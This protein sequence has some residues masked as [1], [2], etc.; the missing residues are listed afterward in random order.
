MV[1]RSRSAKVVD[2][3][4]ERGRRLAEQL[5]PTLERSFV[6]VL[7]SSLDSVEEWRAAA[8]MAGRANGWRVR[9]GFTVDEERVW[10]VRDDLEPDENDLRAA[11]DRLDDL[12]FGGDRPEAPKPPRSPRSTAGLFALP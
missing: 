10:A 11:A 9:T 4:R 5:A 2:L 1:T 6:V 3:R 7:A 12:L 8:R